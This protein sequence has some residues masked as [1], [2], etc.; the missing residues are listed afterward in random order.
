MRPLSIEDQAAR[1]SL[2]EWVWES[3]EVNGLVDK[4][5]AE[6]A[7]TVID[8]IKADADAFIATEENGAAHISVKLWDGYFL[9]FDLFALIEDGFDEDIWDR[10]TVEP[11]A[12]KLRDMANKILAR[13]EN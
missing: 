7:G 13:F 5:S 9:I 8:Q 12:I 1:A 10:E 3:D 6:A 4:I 11:A 2:P